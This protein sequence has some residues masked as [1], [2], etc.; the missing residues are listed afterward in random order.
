MEYYEHGGWAVAKLSWQLI[1]IEPVII[2]DGDP[3]FQLFG[4]SQWW[5]PEPIGYGNDM[6]WTYVNGNVISN[7]V[8]WNPSLPVAG[9]YRVEAHIPNNHATT[10]SARYAIRANG[11]THTATVNQNIY[12]NQW[13]TLGTFA[14]NASNNGTEYVE[15]TDATGESTSTYWK[16]GFDA[17]RFVSSTAPPPTDTWAFPIGSADSASGWV[18]TN[19]LGN[20]WTNGTRWYRGHLGEDWSRS[21]GSL[22]QPV[23]SAAAGT[24]ITVL[25]NCG[26][27]VDV[28]I[29]EHQVAG[30]GEPVYSF[31]GHIEADGYV[32]E[33][34]FVEKRQQIGVIGDPVTFGP[35]LHFEIKNRT[36]LI[37]PPFSS[38]ASVANGVY[39]SAGYSGVSNDYDGGEYYDPSNDSVVG[40]RYYHPTR[41]INARK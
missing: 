1:S 17:M 20:S 9:S 27:Y 37:N 32:Q 16:I 25:Q 6:V 28:V 29:I 13:V 33:G 8:R 24:V 35:H 4:P 14:F 34:D 38:C 19:G 36:A 3:G 40:N 18:M 11:V 10:R 30:I 5:H 7:K 2:D 26:N 15:L 39:I 41:F 21:G 22:G 23:Y 31:Y 12:Y